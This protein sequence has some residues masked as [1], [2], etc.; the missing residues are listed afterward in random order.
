MDTI[1]DEVLLLV[2]YAWPFPDQALPSGTNDSEMDAFTERTGVA[3]PEELRLWLRHCNGAVIGS[4][5]VYGLVEMEQQ[6]HSH[7]EWVEK[8]W[9]AVANDGC[10][11]PYVLDTHTLVEDTHPVYFIDHETYEGEADYVVASGLW[12][13]LR[14][15]LTREF[16]REK[17]RKNAQMYVSYWPFYEPRVLAEDP[18]LAHYQGKVPLPWEAD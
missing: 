10:G 16:D 7:P 14:F 18:A 8:G 1:Q 15:L 11:D 12:P 5:G 6:Y 4:G 9:I 17:S 2:K 3:I 13:F